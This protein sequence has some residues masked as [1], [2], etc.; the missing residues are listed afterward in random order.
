MSKRILRQAKAR[1]QVI[2][3]EA[4]TGIKERTNQ[5]HPPTRWGSLYG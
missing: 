1:N 4:L 2:V 5:Q 3:L